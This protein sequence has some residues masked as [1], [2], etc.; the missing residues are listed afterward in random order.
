MSV[1][2]IVGWKASSK[3]VVD[4]RFGVLPFQKAGVK[5]SERE[6]DDQLALQSKKTLTCRQYDSRLFCLVNDT[7]HL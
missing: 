4:P 7:V 1:Y 6:W 2:I 5:C 3:P